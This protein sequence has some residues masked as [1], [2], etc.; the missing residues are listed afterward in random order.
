PLAGHEEDEA[1]DAAREQERPRAIGD[2]RSHHGAIVGLSCAF[3]CGF[4]R[5]GRPSPPERTYAP[6]TPSGPRSVVSDRRRRRGRGCV[7]G[8]SM[9]RLLISVLMLIGGSVW[10]DEFVL[11]RNAANPTAQVSANEVKD[12]YTGKRKQWENGAPVQVVL[13]GEDSPELGWLAQ[14]F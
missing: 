7:L 4:C 10:A 11:V 5:R 6:K 8:E 3:P 9:R 14:T 1:K 2:G 12:L 13:T